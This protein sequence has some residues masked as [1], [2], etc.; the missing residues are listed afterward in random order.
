MTRSKTFRGALGW[1]FA[2]SWGQR[3][4]A[5]VFTFVLAAMLGPRVYGIVA[6]AIAFTSLALVFL[7]QGI[8]TAIVQREN[9][10][11]EHLDTAFWLNTGWALVLAGLTVA[12][13]GPW[14]ALNDV[15]E[16]RG[17]L[18]ALA[19]TLL[20][21]GLCV[22]QMARLQRGMEFR[23]LAISA[24]IATLLGGVAG[25][26]LAVA[27]AG[28]WALVA[29]QLVY[30]GGMCVLLFALS[31]WRPRF[32]YSGSHAGE[33][34]RY[35]SSVMVANLGGFLNRRSDALLLGLFFGPAVVG[36]YRLADRLVDTLLELTMRP[37][38]MVSLPH[39]SRLQN[40]PVGLRGAV[41]SC[42]KITFVACIP[43]LL[44]LAATSPWILALIGPEWEVGATALKL[45][46]IVGI[47]KSLVYFTG[48]L[49][50][51][52]DRPKLRAGM[53]WLFAAI[54]VVTVVIV[55]SALEGAKD[56]AQLVG[57]AAVRAIV[58]AA[59]IVPLNLYVIRKLTGLRLKTV[60]PWALA[61]AAAGAA[62]LLVGT[63]LERSGVLDGLGDLV[64]LV[65][66]S[67]ATVGL[68]LLLLPM[69]DR[70]IRVEMRRM[71]AT[72]RMSRSPERPASS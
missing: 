5:T 54:S 9:L 64:A 18:I 68:V 16:V 11:P 37:V 39:F 21:A 3:L 36:V 20:L 72:V 4:M 61:P 48:P 25:I 13:A 67:V 57:M 63:L 24:N 60:A 43:T 26:G 1:A 6:I 71:L 28:V 44:V 29:Q 8:S 70:Q 35:S 32:R 49:L 65:V 38:G 50:F 51:A 27:G 46:C 53:L 10:E 55:G 66:A 59:V 34:L 30:D 40:D 14:A 33:L 45:L 41:A 2:M 62:A 17:A 52:V 22:V 47:A 69:L 23:R 15:P 19:P 31:P 7:E 42:M 56:N 12:A 58:F